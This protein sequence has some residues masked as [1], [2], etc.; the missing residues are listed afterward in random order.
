ME[1]DERTYIY[2][3]IFS[4]VGDSDMVD[5]GERIVSVHS[6]KEKAEEKNRELSV[7]IE[8]PDKEWYYVQKFELDGKKVEEN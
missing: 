3:L 4:W 7:S 2:V 5:D 1:P 8:D 6:T